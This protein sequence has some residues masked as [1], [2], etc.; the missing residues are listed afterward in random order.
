MALNAVGRMLEAAGF[1]GELAVAE[2][3]TPGRVFV[4]ERVRCGG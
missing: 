4:L 2:R 1:Q 3:D